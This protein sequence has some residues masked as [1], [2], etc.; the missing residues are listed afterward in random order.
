MA[1][2]HFE[3][4]VPIAGA[5]EARAVSEV[6]TWMP[7]MMQLFAD[8]IKDNI[9]LVENNII[10]LTD[11]IK[12]KISDTVDSAFNWGWDMLINFNNGIVDA[13]DSVI[14]TVANVASSIKSY[15]GFSEPEKGA[16][17]DFHTY[18]PD[19]MKLFAQGIK[20]NQNLVI[21]QAE[22]LSNNLAD[23]IQNPIQ[24]P[25]QITV[26]S[27][28]SGFT[29]P[30]L[31]DLQNQEYTV[32]FLDN[33][34]EIIQK[35][36]EFALSE[37][38]TELSFTADTS[39]FDKIRELLENPL[40]VSV[41]LSDSIQKLNSMFADV[42]LA[43]PEMNAVQPY[44]NDYS[45]QIEDIKNNYST[46][47]YYSSIENNSYASSRNYE[48][49]SNANSVTVQNLTINIP[50]FNIESPSDMKRLGD[51]LKDTIIEN[52]DV[53]AVRDNRDLGGIGWTL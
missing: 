8:G 38:L 15:L 27:K 34:D 40:V 39:T 25:F 45:K 20:E 29:I 42:S 49:E 10:S 13:Y 46:T 35:T 17:S 26:D 11:N 36:K 16:L 37:K 1:G 43:S 21:S 52:L 32:T 7:D 12:N 9:H 50:G 2:A 5:M 19:M 3:K 41:Q 22:T 48:N 53:Q 30:A 24:S 6:D 23:T 4:S 31:P 44:R 14:Q 47:N 28:F 33:L 18:A 51:A